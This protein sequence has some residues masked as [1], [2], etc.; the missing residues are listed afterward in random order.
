VKR[1]SVEQ[2]R[3]QLAEAEDKI[4][5]LAVQLRDRDTLA[6]RELAA[7]QTSLRETQAS[8]DLAEDRAA[9]MLALADKR[10]EEIETS[11]ANSVR[12]AGHLMDARESH[13]RTKGI[14][15]VVTRLVLSNNVDAAKA[16]AL[17]VKDE[18]GS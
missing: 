3:R 8:R 14:L 15:Y 16:V 13:G 7:L 18:V 12:L 4:G 11:Q 10:A 5:R 17:G 1:S 2:V 6:Q 9:K